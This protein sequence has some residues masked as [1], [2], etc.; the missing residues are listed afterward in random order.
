MPRSLTAKEQLEALKL[1]DSLPVGSAPRRAILAAVKST[2]LDAYVAIDAALGTNIA[3]SA[4][5][6]QHNYNGIKFSWVD[7]PGEIELR[8]DT[9]ADAKVLKAAL[10]KGGVLAWIDRKD[11]STLHVET[12]YKF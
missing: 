10:K 7:E 1:A 2:N 8:C 3:D 12:N 5:A 11:S 4:F 6:S 9:S